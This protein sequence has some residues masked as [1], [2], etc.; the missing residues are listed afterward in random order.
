M[1][2]L[3]ARSRASIMESKIGDFVKAGMPTQIGND[4]NSAA[5]KHG[6]MY[7]GYGYLNRTKN[8]TMPGTA[9]TSGWGGPRT[10]RNYSS[11]RMVVVFSSRDAWM[12]EVYE[13]AK[14]WTAIKN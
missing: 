14:D 1:A 8:T 5:R 3:L 2:A 7:G 11:D 13:L 6:R 4:H 12:P 10:G 9:W